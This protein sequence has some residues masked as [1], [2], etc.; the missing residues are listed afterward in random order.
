MGMYSFVDEVDL[1]FR[2]AQHK[3]LLIDE[4]YNA[5]CENCSN[6]L[7]CI[8]RTEQQKQ[9]ECPKNLLKSY[10]KW[11]KIS[12]SFSILLDD[13]KIISYWYENTLNFL[14]MIAKY[15]EGHI[16]LAF[17]KIEFDEGNC[18]IQL[19]QMNWTEYTPDNLR[20]RRTYASMGKIS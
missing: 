8:S 9:Y 5:T 10:F 6:K 7:R 20:V 12:D 3:Q 17:A 14:K 13:R 19:G 18:T 4:C 15:I 2:S 1:S 11:D 16:E